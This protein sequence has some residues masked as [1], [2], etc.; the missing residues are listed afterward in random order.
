MAATTA[1]DW[2]ILGAG[3][4]GCLWA[5]SWQEHGG[6]PILILRDEASL[7]HF[8][9]ND[10]IVL[11]D[12]D[13]SHLLQPMTV[14]TQNLSGPVSR[15]LITTKAWQMQSALETIG[16]KLAAEASIVL[17]QNGMG[18]EEIVSRLFPGARIYPAV[19]TDGVWRERPFTITR[20]GI[21]TTWIGRSNGAAPDDNDRSLLES[22][23]H[24]ALTIRYSR[25][26]RRRQW[27]K[28]AVNSI[29]NPLTALAGCRNGELSANVDLERL[30]PA[31]ADEI[32]AVAAADGIALGT[33]EIVLQTRE[34]LT[35]TAAN[36]SSMLQDI[37]AGRR[38]EIDTING[39]ICQ[40]AQ[41]HG[42]AVPENRRLLNAVLARQSR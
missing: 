32:A 15:L 30:L 12:G 3:A 24:A 20:T 5:A 6:S 29:I 33:A 38:T 1:S 4:L 14:T 39:Y 31:L 16:T 37:E 13:G 26:I 25:D 28:L 35:A 22:L 42:L 18:N 36:R 9:A 19:T 40:R 27:Q 11:T 7:G 8:K 17:L 41:L 21:G 23:P 10:G 34:V 2:H